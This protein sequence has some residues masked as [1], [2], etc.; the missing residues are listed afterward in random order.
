MI[1]AQHESSWPR[2]SQ[3]APGPGGP[4]QAP[5]SGSTRSGG[6]LRLI[7]FRVTR[8]R[9]T[10]RDLNGLLFFYIASEQG[11]AR[12][13]LHAR[14]EFWPGPRRGRAPPGGPSA[15]GPTVKNEG[16]GC[17]NLLLVPF[18]I[19]EILHPGIFRAIKFN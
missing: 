13:S 8:F 2:P 17:L 16:K 1:A 19:Y 10:S 18:N 3:S 7:G 4:A 5:Y 6:S 9:A 11:C 12:P 15:L 14:H